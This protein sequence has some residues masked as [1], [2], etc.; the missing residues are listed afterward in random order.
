MSD[1]IIDNQIC[2]ETSR[3]KSIFKGV[4]R[5]SIGLFFMVSA[6][7]KLFSI[8]EFEIYIYSFNVI[9]FAFGSLL[10]RLVIAFELLTGALFIFKFYY[11]KVWLL[12]LATT[13]CFTIFLIYTAIFRSDSNCHCMGEF[14]K[15]NPVHSI[16][17]N[18]FIIA[19]LVVLRKEKQSI[20]RRRK[21]ITIIFVVL[22]TLLPFVLFPTD[23]VY[24]YIVK[25]EKNLNISEFDK[26]VADTSYDKKLSDIRLDSEKD[27]IVY[28]VERTHLDFSK[29]T[30]LIIYAHSGCEYCVLAMKK[31]KLIFDNNNISKEKCKILIWGDEKHISAFI[32]E[33]ETS[34]FEFRL[35]DPFQA[36]SITNGKFP[37]FAIVENSKVLVDFNFRSLNEKQIVESLK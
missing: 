16:I 6:V 26:S 36:I 30:F 37:T 29:D 20:Y 31:I 22:S 7:L 12:L 11:K 19:L 27:S 23:S 14:V 17:K 35:V 8:D 3:R 25:G 5:I 21:L 28:S 18:I 2:V 32:K 34:D 24:R 13:I 1:T 9:N 4:V 33:T 15:L 10:A